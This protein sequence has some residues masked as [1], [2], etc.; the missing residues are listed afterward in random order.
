MATVRFFTLA[1]RTVT[2]SLSPADFLRGKGGVAYD[3]GYR[4]V[5]TSTSTRRERLGRCSSSLRLA[6]AGVPELLALT[7]EEFR[8]RCSI[9]L[10]LYHG[11]EALVCFRHLFS[12]TNMLMYRCKEVDAKDVLIDDRKHFGGRQRRWQDDAGTGALPSCEKAS[13]DSFPRGSA[14]AGSAALPQ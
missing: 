14:D 13:L 4:A 10:K 1:V 6:Y 11:Q 3:F 5:K 7:T 12:I 9:L 2:A 8:E